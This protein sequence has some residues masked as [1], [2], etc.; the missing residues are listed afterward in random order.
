MQART[1]HEKAHGRW[2]GGH[3]LS[4]HRVGHQCWAGAGGEWP[5]EDGCGS[6]L[7]SPDKGASEKPTQASSGLRSR[8]HT[9]ASSEA[10]GGSQGT[11]TT[12]TESSEDAGQLPFYTAFHHLLVT[13]FQ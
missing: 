2:C 1:N 6:I 3:V 4:R 9:R 7:R 12:A 10:V 8:T 11:V 13:C 5:V